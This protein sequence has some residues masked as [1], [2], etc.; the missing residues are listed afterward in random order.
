MKNNINNYTFSR[1]QNA[2]WKEGYHD[3]TW[4]WGS[5]VESGPEF[6]FSLCSP[7][8]FQSS[9]ENIYSLYSKN[10]VKNSLCLHCFIKG[11][12]SLGR[13]DSICIIT[14]NKLCCYQICRFYFHQLYC[15]SADRSEIL[16]FFDAQSL[17]FLS[18]KQLTFSGKAFSYVSAVRILHN[19]PH[20]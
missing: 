3:D 15:F 6:I 14:A 9:S 4:S 20:S 10:I 19:Y 11:M 16:F 13:T 5:A 12:T 2:E 17:C 1:T 8:F 7:L 18:N